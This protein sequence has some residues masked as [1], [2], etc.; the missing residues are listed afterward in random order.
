MSRI[1]RTIEARSDL[2][3]IALYIIV[4]G[5]ELVRVLHTAQEIDAIF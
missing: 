4:D 1:S 5:I 2:I 3:G